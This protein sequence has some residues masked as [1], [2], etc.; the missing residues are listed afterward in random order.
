MAPKG[1]LMVGADFNSVE[2]M[3]SALTTKDKN[4][5]KV[6]LDGFDGHSL[7]AAYYFQ[8]DLEAEGIFIDMSD[9]KSVNQLKKMNHPLR[10]KSKPPTFLLTYGGTYHGM[11]KNLGWPEDMSKTIEANYH[12]LYAESDA[13]IQKRLKQAAQDGYVEV[14]FGLRVRTPLLG[15]VVYGSARMPYAA[16][17]EGRTAGNAMGQSFGLLNNRSANE[18]MVKVWNSPYRLDILPIA[19]IH[20]AQYYLVRDNPDVVAWA[21]REMINSMRWQELPEI[22]HP[23]VKLGANLDIFWPS[24]ANGITLPNDANKQEI[25]DICAKAKTDYLNPKPKKE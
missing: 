22:Q 11:M 15:Q 17:A 14:A 18:F 10:S 23:T 12:V 7:R 9:P 2:D 4:K 19:Q 20:D 6:Y 16:S 24:W 13:Y 21:N 5:L 3:I 1:W 8:K 25:I